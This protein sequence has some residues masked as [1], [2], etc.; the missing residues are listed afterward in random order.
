[1]SYKKP[2]FIRARL[3]KHNYAN[4]LEYFHTNKKDD[5]FYKLLSNY[6]SDHL[7]KTCVQESEYKSVFDE[8]GFYFKKDNLVCYDK[9]NKV[10]LIENCIDQDVVMKLTIILYD[11]MDDEKRLVG[12]CIKVKEIRI[13]ND[14]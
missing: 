5:H 7:I 12:C 9:F 1:M 4:F 14:R 3:R 2:I 11:F 8:E 13:K 6:S 10:C